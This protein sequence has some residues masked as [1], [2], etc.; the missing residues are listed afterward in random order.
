MIS[1]VAPL[2]LFAD[3]TTGTRR[4]VPSVDEHIRMLRPRHRMREI[5]RRVWLWVIH[6]PV[7]ASRTVL[8]TRAVALHNL[9]WATPKTLL[10][11][12]AV[13]VLRASQA[14]SPRR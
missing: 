9:A 8:A 1:H 5:G 14:R 6:Q 12:R 13:H 4:P 7:L 11:L 3:P 2:R 10:A